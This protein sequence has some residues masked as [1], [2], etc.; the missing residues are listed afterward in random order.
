MQK[1]A[2]ASAALCSL[3]SSSSWCF[4]K[5]A[6]GSRTLFVLPQYPVGVQFLAFQE[7]GCD[8]SA[9]HKLN[10]SLSWRCKAY[11]RSP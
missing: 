1:A 5:P 7:E 11:W 2:R 10:L 6:G 9:H 3:A 8:L 4:D